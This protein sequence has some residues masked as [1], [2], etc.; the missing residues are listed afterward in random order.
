MNIRRDQK[1]IQMANTCKYILTLL[2]DVLFFGVGLLIV[3]E[4]STVLALVC[5]LKAMCT[6]SLLPIKAYINV[7]TSPVHTEDV[8]YIHVYRVHMHIIPA[9]LLWWGGIGC[10]I[11]TL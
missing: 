1:G 3:E 6:S 10:A 9:T 4:L 5:C 11:F 8:Q 2:A 7:C